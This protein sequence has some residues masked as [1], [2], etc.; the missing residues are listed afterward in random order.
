METEHIF[1]L[2]GI[3]TNL[4]KYC[5]QFHNLENWLNDP[6]VDCITPFNL[7]ESIEMHIELEKEL[8]KF[9]GSF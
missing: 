9:E 2:V 1:S 3:L 7:M 4:R 6:K 5:L 8:K